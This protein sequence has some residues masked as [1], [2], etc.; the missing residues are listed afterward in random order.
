MNICDVRNEADHT[1]DDLAAQVETIAAQVVPVLEET[2]KLTVGPRPVIRILQPD[3]WV[4]A[5]M[6]DYERGCQRD[7]ADLDL[8]QQDID[9]LPAR[10]KAR[11]EDLRLVWPLVMGTTIEAADRTPQVL[12]V[13]E[14]L[15][16]NGFQEPELM[17]VVAHELTHVAQHVAGDGIAF[18]AQQTTFP[19][20]RGFEGVMAA[21]FLTGHARWT[22]LLVTTELLG[23]EVS[24]DT[25]RQSEQ[26]V[27]LRQQMNRRYQTDPKKHPGLPRAAYL[28]GAHWVRTVIG[29]VG[30]HA[31]NRA[32]K[33]PHLMPTLVEL[34]EPDAWVKRIA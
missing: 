20:K 2:T 5:L 33:D 11:E 28:Q 27:Q 17:K 1:A 14:S 4:S 32:W 24:V 10:A 16:H 13:P 26:S 7:I 19:A 6:E 18:L 15:Q 31:F 8:S 29:E 12:L 9:S 3:A 25:G 23:R 22:D 21:H 30:P 34:H